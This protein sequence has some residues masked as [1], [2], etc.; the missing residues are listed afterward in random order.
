[1][2]HSPFAYHRFYVNKHITNGRKIIFPSAFNL[3]DFVYL[4]YKTITG[5]R[6]ARS[7]GDPGS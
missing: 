3:V 1:M 7:A 4:F 5:W 6:R 2:A